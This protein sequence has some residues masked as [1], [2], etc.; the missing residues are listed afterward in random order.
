MQKIQGNE[1]SPTRDVDLICGYLL[2]REEPAKVPLSSPGFYLLVDRNREMCQPTQI[3]ILQK[4][5]A[6]PQRFQW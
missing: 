4:N 3:R 5:V 2:G 1:S 6:Q